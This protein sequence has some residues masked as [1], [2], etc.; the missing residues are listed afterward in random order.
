MLVKFRSV[1]AHLPHSAEIYD[2]DGIGRLWDSGILLAVFADYP[3][4]GEGKFSSSA[5]FGSLRESISMK[6]S[7]MI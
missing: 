2:F 4:G 3:F 5:F 1:A 6:S 7:V